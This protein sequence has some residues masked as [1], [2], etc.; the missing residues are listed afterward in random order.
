MKGVASY[1]NVRGEGDAAGEGSEEGGG[2]GVG[3]EEGDGA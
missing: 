3:D 2:D 1:W